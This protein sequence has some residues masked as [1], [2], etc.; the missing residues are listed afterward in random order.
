MAKGLWSEPQLGEVAFLQVTAPRRNV[1][2]ADRGGMKWSADAPPPSQLMYVCGCKDAKAAQATWKRLRRNG[3]AVGFETCLEGLNT[4]PILK[5]FG[6][7]FLTRCRIR[8]VVFPRF[9]AGDLAKIAWL[10]IL[11]VAKL[12]TRVGVA[13][14]VW[15]PAVDYTSQACTS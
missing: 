5:E 15:I 3:L 6:P 10:G 13:S 9:L 2:L 11:A 14:S 12:Y 1:V 4:E 8:L 7:T